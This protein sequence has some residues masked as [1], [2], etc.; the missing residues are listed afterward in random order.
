MITTPT[1]TC[2]GKVLVP[3]ID[4]RD[5][6]RVQA[7]SYTEIIESIAVENH[8]T[9]GVLNTVTLQ[10]YTDRTDYN[11][12]NTMFRRDHLHLRSD[13]DRTSHGY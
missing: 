12:R 8:T 5:L 4:T 9:T 1:G 6:S 13:D 2:R 11:R 3:S 7:F 10:Q